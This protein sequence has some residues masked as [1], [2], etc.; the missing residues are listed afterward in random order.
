[1]A[2]H[3]LKAKIVSARVMSGDISAFHKLAIRT[4]LA[5][6]KLRFPASIFKWIEPYS[7][8]FRFVTLLLAYGD[9]M[10]WLGNNRFML[11]EVNTLFKLNTSNYYWLKSYFESEDKI[12]FDYQSGQL[13]GTIH[14]LRFHVPD[15][16]SAQILAETFLE[17]TY[18][19]FDMKDNVVL[20]IG[21]YVGDTAVYF[22]CRGAKKIVAY[23]PN[24]TF[25]EM[26]KENAELNG[27]AGKIAVVNAGI[28]AEDGFLQLDNECK[29]KQ[30]SIKSALDMVGHVDLLKM[31][32]EGAEWEI[33]AKSVSEGLLETVGKIIMEVHG[34]HPERMEKILNQTK[35]TVRKLVS[36]GKDGMLIAASRD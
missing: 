1:L 19:F 4:G 14:N 29:V 32:C 10:R 5:L 26:A 36:Y 23:E 16:G 25:A 31:D 20:D 28:G 11:S 2:P 24:P 12:R 22:A 18:G 34:F 6:R 3:R 15:L 17:D 33:M 13:Y 21:A 30:V 7:F 8:F 27:F 9:K 35:Y